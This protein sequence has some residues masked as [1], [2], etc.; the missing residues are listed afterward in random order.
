MTA[1]MLPGLSSLVFQLNRADG[2]VWVCRKPPQ[3]MEPTC[4]QGIC[5]PHVGLPR[6]LGGCAPHFDKSW[7]KG[8][9]HTVFSAGKIP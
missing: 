5:A 7:T 2:R 1:N 8:P 9:L 6:P 4:R 3:V